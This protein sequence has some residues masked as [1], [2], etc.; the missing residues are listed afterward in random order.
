M[1]QAFGAATPS[2]PIDCHKESLP[3]PRE[4]KQYHPRGRIAYLQPGKVPL[5]LN[6]SI[7][8]QAVSFCNS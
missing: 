8:S 6:A 4:E 2:V 5:H 7:C 1:W 3:K